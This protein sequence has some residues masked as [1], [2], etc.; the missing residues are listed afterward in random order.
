MTTVIDA[1]FDGNVFRPA[2]PVALEPNTAVRLTVE[3]ASPP[4]TG[5]PYSF[6]ETALSLKIE[7]PADWSAKVD[8]Y[9]YG[10]ELHGDE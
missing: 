4:P 2:Q 8:K 9:L 6:L 5:K 7:G 1:M 10:E 3:S